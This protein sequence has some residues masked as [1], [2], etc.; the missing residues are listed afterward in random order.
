MVWVGLAASVVGFAVSQIG[1]ILRAFSDFV[2]IMGGVA[3]LL[4][5]LVYVMRW[6]ADRATLRDALD[7]LL[8]GSA[9]VALSIIVGALLVALAVGVGLR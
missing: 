7:V 8:F 4:V 9:I 5:Y 1:K 3:L 2:L 6:L